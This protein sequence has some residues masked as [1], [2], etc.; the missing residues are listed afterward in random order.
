[1][2]A[3]IVNHDHI[4][5]MLTAGLAGRTIDI[6]TWMDPALDNDP[7]YP[8]AFTRGHPWGPSAIELAEKYRRTLRTTN[9]TT[10][11]SM[12]LAENARSVA[13][14][15]D[16]NDL[17]VE[18]DQAGIYTFRSLPATPNPVLVLK[19]IDCYEHQSC[20]RPDWENTEAHAFCDAL[21]R[22]LIRSLAGYDDAPA[23]EVHDRRVAAAWTPISMSR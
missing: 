3:F 4:D 11:G 16:E 1:M 6:V 13:Y 10:V 8:E 22:R 21:R 9:A 19:A 18:L 14:R 15:Y 12:L 20:E 7:R 5:T 2:S 23:W 17:D